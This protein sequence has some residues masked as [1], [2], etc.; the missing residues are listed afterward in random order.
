MEDLLKDCGL[1]Y[2][3]TRET[4]LI[5]MTAVTSLKVAGDLPYSFIYSIQKKVFLLIPVRGQ[6]RQSC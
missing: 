3:L 2:V 6:D 4:L 1:L 5:H